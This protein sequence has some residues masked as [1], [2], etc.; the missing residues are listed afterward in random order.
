MRRLSVWRRRSVDRGDGGKGRKK[1][2]DLQLSRLHAH[3]R[4]NEKGEIYCASV[5]DA[6]EVASEAEG[7]IRR[8]SKP[9]AQSRP[10]TGSLFTV[11]RWRSREILWRTH[12]QRGQRGFQRK[13]MPAV[14]QSVEAPQQS[15]K[16][17]LTW[18]RM[19]RLIDRYIP[20]ARIACFFPH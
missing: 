18:D 4:D 11:G 19:G 2:G 13:S 14:D 1:T 17:S 15:D 12:E 7:V 6:Q 10:G 5:D 16:Y 20:Q 8:T 9:H 3:M